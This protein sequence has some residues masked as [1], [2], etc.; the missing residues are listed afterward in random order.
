MGTRVRTLV[1]FFNVP[2]GS[3][4]V[5]DEDYQTGVMVR[6]DLPHKIRDGFDKET[7]LHFLEK[8]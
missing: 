6:W 1:A 4:G 2:K 5:I 7:E 8:V 3:E